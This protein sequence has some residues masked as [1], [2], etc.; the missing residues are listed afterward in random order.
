MNNDITIA[1]ENLTRAIEVEDDAVK[2]WTLVTVASRLGISAIVTAHDDPVVG[3]TEVGEMWCD[4][5][6]QQLEDGPG[7]R[8]ETLRAAHGVVMRLLEAVDCSVRAA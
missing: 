1:I 2:V 4:T 5:V 3:I 7:R 8:G 6:A